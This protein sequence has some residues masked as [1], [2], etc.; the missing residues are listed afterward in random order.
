MDDWLTAER[1]VH[2]CAATELAEAEGEF[3][4]KVAMPGFDHQELHVT[5]LPN[6]IIVQAE[7]SNERREQKGEV[8]W[9]EFS[10]EQVLRRV[11]LPAAVDVDTITATLDKG[12]LSI[13]APKATAPRQKPAEKM[14][15]A[16]A[17]G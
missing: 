7:R 9:S 14:K 11:P 16:A 4:L 13:V 8:R 15:V 3:Q 1:E 10:T 12:V 6:E 17:A 2:G 5:A